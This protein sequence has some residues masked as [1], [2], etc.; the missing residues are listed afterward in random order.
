MIKKF[1]L[2]MLIL[3]TAYAPSVYAANIAQDSGRFSYG[4]MR[5]VRGAFQLPVSVLGGTL[6]GPPIVGTI[7]GVVQGTFRTVADVTGGIF[8]MGV[9]AAPYAKYAAL[10]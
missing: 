4:A 9:A 2:A 8:H 5:I 6:S 3:S 7:G 1:A 10:A